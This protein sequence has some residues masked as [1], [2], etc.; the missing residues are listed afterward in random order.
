MEL[1]EYLKNDF[2]VYVEVNADHMADGRIFPC[3]F[4]WEDGQ[5]YEIDSVISVCPA[6]SLKGGG[7][8]MRYTVRIQ[9]RVRFMFLEEDNGISRW[10]MER[11]ET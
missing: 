8:G 7:A 1:A 9:G 3:S 2:K 11:R 4:L 10:F 5:R 6:A